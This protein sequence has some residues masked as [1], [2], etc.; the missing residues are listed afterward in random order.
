MKLGID[1]QSSKERF[2][3]CIP[4]KKPNIREFT[5]IKLKLVASEADSFKMETKNRAK[6]SSLNL[7]QK[8]EMLRTADQLW[9]TIHYEH[10][11]E[12]I[13]QGMQTNSTR[14]VQGTHQDM[15]K[16]DQGQ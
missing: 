12:R 1:F 14:D 11:N 13:K 7:L 6:S 9:G 3:K 10:S 8:K 15:P 16:N 4:R 5:P 2:H